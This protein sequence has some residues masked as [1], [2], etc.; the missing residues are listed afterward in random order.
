LTT[1]MKRKRYLLAIVA[2]IGCSIAWI[3]W[4]NSRR[5]T[6]TDD[7]Y[8]AVSEPAV[9]TDALR[10]TGRLPVSNSLALRSGDGTSRHS[11]PKTRVGQLREGAEERNVPIAFWGKVVDQFDSPIPGARIQMEIREWHLRLLSPLEPDFQTF[12]QT[13]DA[14][15]VFHLANAR[16][17]VLTIK[18]LNKDGYT[19]SQN[20][21]RSF[22]YNISTNHLPDPN[23]PVT[24]RM[25]KKE[26]PQPLE[27][28]RLSRVGIPCDGTPVAFD[29]L[30]GK[31]SQARKDLTVTL[32][33]N[34]QNLTSRGDK[35]D[36]TAVLQVH[37]GGLIESADEFMFLAPDGG[38]EPLFRVE[39]T[40]ESPNWSSHLEKQFYIRLRSGSVFGKIS[41]RL[42]TNYQPPPAGLTMEITMN[43]TGS[44]SLER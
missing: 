14:F 34:P 28:K 22:G 7:K 36:W 33:R 43:P 9:D 8:R 26:G 17:D 5:A 10:S 24:V 6:P 11:D 35:Y 16:G 20:S 40:K 42:S 37:D 32:V 4:Q 3:L 1:I 15:G 44:R 2:L 19:A 25:W 27:S 31:K 13:T 29:L 12:E 30:T 23:N 39:M 38:Y 18:S 41:V 21:L